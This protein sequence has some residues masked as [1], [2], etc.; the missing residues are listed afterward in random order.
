VWLCSCNGY[1]G[2]PFE[3]DARSVSSACDDALTQ[4]PHLPRGLE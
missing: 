1:I 4:C 3:L 2:D